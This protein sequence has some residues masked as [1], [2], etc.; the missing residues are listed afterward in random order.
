MEKNVNEK[1]NV[2]EK[3]NVNA[4][5]K[6]NTVVNTETGEIVE[7]KKVSLF[8][9]R[10]QGRGTN[11]KMYMNYFV[12]GKLRGGDSRADLVT[13]DKGGYEY[14]DKEVFNG[15][16][17]MPLTVRQTSYQAA[18]GKVIRKNAYWVVD[19]DDDGTH[20]EIQLKGRETSDISVLESLISK[21]G[22]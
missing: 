14:I 2:T 11:G 1:V 13:I 10:K 4:T 19:D 15:R 16:D 20:Y 12:I 8:V 22:I 7:E 6:V 18:D 5:E 21:Y 9:E 3:A 17:K